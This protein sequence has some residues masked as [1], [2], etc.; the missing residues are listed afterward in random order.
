MN[1]SATNIT[2]GLLDQPTSDQV[3]RT[4]NRG[5]QTADAGAVGEHQHDGRADAKA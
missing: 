1:A 5:E 3:R 2:G 4:A